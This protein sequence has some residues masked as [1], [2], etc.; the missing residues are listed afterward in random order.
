MSQMSQ[1]RGYRNICPVCPVLRRFLRKF[2]MRTHLKSL[3]KAN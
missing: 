2:L 1:K 3:L